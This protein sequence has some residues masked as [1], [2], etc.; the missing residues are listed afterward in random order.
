MQ[1]VDAAEA[2]FHIE[3]EDE[4]YPPFREVIGDD[5]FFFEAFFACG[6]PEGAFGIASR[7]IFR[8]LVRAAHG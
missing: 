2:A 6:A 4:F 5:G 7:H 1:E 8:Q 3:V